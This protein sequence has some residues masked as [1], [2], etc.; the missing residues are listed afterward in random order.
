MVVPFFSD[1]CS[2]SMKS[3]FICITLLGLGCNLFSQGALLRPFGSTYDDVYQYLEH[4]GSV[5]INT[6]TKDQL[7]ASNDKYEVQHFFRQGR[8]YKTEVV[9]YYRD[10]KGVEDAI[11]SV[12]EQYGR[13][14]ADIMELNS[15][16]DQ[17]MFVAKVDNELHE[18]NQVKLGKK[19]FQ[20]IQVKLDLTECTDQEMNELMEDQL[21][22]GLLK[23]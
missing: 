20:L 19:G 21:L 18:V 7:V 10:R 23:E 8:L 13:W 9:R 5:R 14:E 22:T 4:Q 15:S 11:A 16:R 6:P 1:S 3:L 2:R 12:R 17:I